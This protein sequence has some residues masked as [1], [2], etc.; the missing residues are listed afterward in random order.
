MVLLLLTQSIFT[1]NVIAGAS[2]QFFDGAGIPLTANLLGVNTFSTNGTP[3]HSFSVTDSDLQFIVTVRIT[4]TAGCFDEESVTIFMNYVRDTGVSITG[5]AMSENI[6]SGSAPTSFI[7]S[8]PFVAGDGTNDWN[9]GADNPGT[10]SITYRWERRV[11]PFAALGWLPI[12][13]VAASVSSTYQAP[14]LFQTTEFRRTSISTLNGKVC[15]Q[16]SSSIITIN[17]ATALNWRT[18]RKGYRGCSICRCNT[19]TMSRRHSSITKN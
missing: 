7:G 9:D 14:P 1:A 15:T 8:N 11:A 6:C 16:S 10:A 17:V 2:Y 19:N 3:P 5:G 4:N 18:G 12:G 13:S